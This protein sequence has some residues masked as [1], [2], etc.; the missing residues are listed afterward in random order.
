MLA[1]EGD[2]NEL[3]G[4]HTEGKGMCKNPILLVH[5]SHYSITLYARTASDPADV[6]RRRLLLREHS[7]LDILAM[8]VRELRRVRVIFRHVF[9]RV[10]GLVHCVGRCVFVGILVGDIE[11]RILRRHGVRLG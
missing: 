7:T 6:T 2:W 9:P 1:R 4:K 3:P 8:R 11:G 10:N 5:R